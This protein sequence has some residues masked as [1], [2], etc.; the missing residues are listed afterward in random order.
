[1]RGGCRRHETVIGKMWER[2]EMSGTMIGIRGFIMLAAMAVFV[3][4]SSAGAADRIRLGL[5]WLP[6]A[7]YGGFYQAKADGIYE[8]YGLDVEIDPGSPQKN[9]GQLLAA[10][11]YDV[12]LGNSSIVFNANA[13]GLEFVTAA[14]FFQKEPTILF[15]HDDPEI[16]TIADLKGH[17]AAIT[18]LSVMSFWP[19]LKK[20][21]G[22][23]DDQI[24]P[25]PYSYAF[26]LS[27]EKAIQQ[28]F[29][30]N[31][32][33]QLKR[34]GI[35]VK[36][37]LLADNG[38]NP[39]GNTVIATRK[40]AEENADVL[41][42]FI[43]ATSEGWKAFLHGDSSGAEALILAGN[44]DYTPETFEDAKQAILESGIVEGGDA[45]TG[46]IGTMTDARWKE[47][48]QT[49]V[50]AGNIPDSFDYKS[51][52]TLDFVHPDKLTKP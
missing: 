15:A 11:A 41:Q 2:D 1:M 24:R 48:F 13:V 4:S 12:V 16:E 30:T 37:F 19:T 43:T 44:Q 17:P 45:E 18:N 40:F 29:L 26:F 32:V 38:Y 7:E 39:Y 28:G 9:L 21:Y 49:E 10:G 36:T 33:G 22:F 23:T 47:F 52:Y 8:R 31:D 46:G 20:K 27:N 5:S 3:A 42:R 51:A 6:Q 14:A 35:E 25:Y 34:E 50:E